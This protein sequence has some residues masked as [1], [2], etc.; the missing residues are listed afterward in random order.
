MYYYIINPTA[1]RG[2]I[3]S[4]QEKLRESLTT[5]GIAGE[6]IKTTGPGDATRLAE[7][8]VQNVFQTIVAIGGD[9]TVNE[10]MNGV[11]GSSAAIGIIPIGRTNRLANQLGVQTWQQSLPLLAAR[12]LTSYRLLAAGQ[13]Y[14]LSELTIG[15]ETEQ[16]KTL[17][18]SGSKLRQRVRHFRSSWGR[19][20]RYETLDAHLKIDDD[21]EADC[22]FFTLSV[23]NQKFIDPLGS[24]RL[25]I[26]L[27]DAPNRRQLTSY[28]WQRSGTIGTTQDH[29]TTRLYAEKLLVETTAPAGIMIDG[30][31]SGRTPIAI[32]LT[33]KEVRFICDKPENAFRP[34]EK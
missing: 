4:I 3:N 17:E 11:V 25:V 9:E 21:Y 16:E 24:N 20:R 32:R 27:A 8:A 12:R 2:A 10:V 13:Y 22:Q 31:V 28:L 33:D 7:Q 23:S 19:A 30:K 29:I 34:A 14:F 26:S 5:L 15:F 1:G 18:A 6:F